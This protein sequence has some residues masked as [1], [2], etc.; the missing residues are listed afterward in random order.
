MGQLVAEVGQPL[1]SVVDELAGG[2][3]PLEGH[4]AEKEQA[5]HGEHRD[6]AAAGGVTRVAHLLADAEGGVEAPVAEHRHHHALSQRGER[7]DGEGVE[8]VQAE[9]LGA[10]EEAVAAEAQQHQVLEAQE[11]ALQPCGDVGPGDG[12][13][14]GGHQHRH[15]EQRRLQRAVGVQGQSGQAVQSRL[16]GELDQ[17]RSG[18][19]R[20][21][22][23]EDDGSDDV[24]PAG[25][26]PQPGADRAA[27]PDVAVAAVGLDPVEPGVGRGDAQDRQEGEQHDDRQ[28]QADDPGEQ[29][30]PEADAGGRGG[31]GRGDDHA[32]QHAERP[33]H[34][35]CHRATASLGTGLE[36]HAILR[37][38]NT[39][40]V[41]T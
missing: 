7:G 16:A 34:V 5:E 32:V 36:R 18:H 22:G 30:H 9:R 27:D 15:P 31:G 12:G 23:E 28:M 6:Q 1:R 14:R 8:P 26:E 17:G 38:L 3:D 11:I 21:V 40:M 41:L 20:R 13:E 33:S 24:H 35:C 29:P 2:E 19:G 37:A 10:G 4:R 25:E 39:S